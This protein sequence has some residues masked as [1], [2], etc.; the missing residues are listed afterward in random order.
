M[1][2]YLML[3]IVVTAMCASGFGG[4]DADEPSAGTSPQQRIAPQL[5]LARE[6]IAAAKK[7]GVPVAITNSIEMQMVLIPAGE[8][9]MGTSAPRMDGE[10]MNCSI[11]CAS[12]SHSIWGPRR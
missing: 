12:P 9:V 6:Q 3:L 10:A 7:L 4:V 11:E 8:Y 2:T 5:R 1:K